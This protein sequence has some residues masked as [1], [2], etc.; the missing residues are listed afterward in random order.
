MCGQSVLIERCMPPKSPKTR[1]GQPHG[2]RSKTTI[3]WPTPW[4]GANSE[5]NTHKFS[6]DLVIADP[7][8]NDLKLMTGQTSTTA[9]YEQER[10][11]AI[12]THG[13]GHKKNLFLSRSVSTQW[14]KQTP[15]WLCGCNQW[16]SNIYFRTKRCVKRTSLIFDF[17]RC[18]RFEPARSID[19]CPIVVCTQ[20]GGRCGLGR[21][22]AKPNLAVKLQ[23]FISTDSCGHFL[24]HCCCGDC[25]NQQYQMQ[26]HWCSCSPFSFP[27]FQNCAAS[28]RSLLTTFS[29]TKGEESLLYWMASTNWS[30]G[31]IPTCAVCWMVVFWQRHLLAPR[32]CATAS[33]FFDSAPSVLD[34]H[35]DLLL[36]K[37]E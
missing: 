5:V 29:S 16:G 10:R 12:T 8:C 28:C 34:G 21:A 37:A 33:Q 22:A 27:M 6:L 13:H 23:C 31:K 25:A 20:Q 2:H 35:V 26:R 1:L 17:L 36:R 24:K 7:Y 4:L 11:T 14:A 15:N 19:W 18:C 3:Q 30:N 9:Y 32:P